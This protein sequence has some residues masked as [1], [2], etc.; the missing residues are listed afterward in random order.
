MFKYDDTTYKKLGFS[1]QSN[2]NGAVSSDWWT[3]PAYYVHQRYS[4]WPP[5]FQIRIYGGYN[6]STGTL[7]VGH[8]DEY[9][10]L[11]KKGDI[12]EISTNS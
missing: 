5:P 10:Y 6:A 4:P 12:L 3:P 7:I 2:Y 1:S 8:R 9:G 11:F